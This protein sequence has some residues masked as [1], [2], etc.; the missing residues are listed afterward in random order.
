MHNLK[1]I[2]TSVSDHDPLLLVLFKVDISKKN[3]RF[4][5]ENMWLK[6]PNF[7]KEVTEVWKAIPVGHLL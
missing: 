1:V 2:R 6:D 4:C 5:F 7:T 3:F